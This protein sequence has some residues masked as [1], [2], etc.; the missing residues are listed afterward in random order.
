MMP[1]I[2]TIVDCSKDIG[3]G[4][5]KRVNALI[6]RLEPVGFE[7]DEYLLDNIS[8]DITLSRIN[9]AIKVNDI[10]LIIIDSFLISDDYILKI[11]QYSKNVLVVDDLIGRS[12][13]ASNI[14]TI[15]WTPLADH[16]PIHDKSG[17]SN[18]FFGLQYCP[19]SSDPILKK[20][21]ID[22]LIHLGSGI[23]LDIYIKVVE[24][25][26]SSLS[27]PKIV[28]ISKHKAGLDNNYQGVKSFLAL[29]L[30]PEELFIEYLSLSTFTVTTGGWTSYQALSKGSR[31]LLISVPESTT[32]YDCHG[33]VYSGYGLP[34]GF[35]DQQNNFQ[36]C[37]INAFKPSKDL[38]LDQIGD[39]FSFIKD[40][41]KGS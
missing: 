36:A 24:S 15:D 3:N 19:I 14:F 10:Q 5:V 28:V 11:S 18:N 1:K 34:F 17:K 9:S 12:L 16:N 20:K 13:S 29:D 8:L 35:I 32:Y 25:L 37:D 22:Y 6:R 26:F 2:I 41:L 23:N 38:M 33:F 21:N 4:H 7:I 27:E 40:L 39:C 31:P 30:L